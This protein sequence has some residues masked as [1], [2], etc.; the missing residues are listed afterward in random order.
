M[1]TYS[2]V[3][4]IRDYTRV[5]SAEFDDEAVDR[6][7]SAASAKIDRLTGRTWQAVRTITDQYYTGDGTNRLYLDN[8]DIGSISA[9][10]I[11]ISSTGST[12]TDITT[13]RVRIASDSGIIELQPDAEVTYFPT[14]LNSV[15]ISYTYGSSTVPIDI[16]QACRYLVAKA[17]KRD[18]ELDP[19]FTFII[20]SYRTNSYRIV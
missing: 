12:Y 13:S 16:K 14:Y 9:L 17:I 20:N 11:N 2:T 18:V 1:T 15:K 6:M 10:S 5:G 7:I 19:D 8:K 3:D 4:E